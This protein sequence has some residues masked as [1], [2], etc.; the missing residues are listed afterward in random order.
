[1]AMI[2]IPPRGNVT[3]KFNPTPKGLIGANPCLQCLSEKELLA[4]LAG[5]MATGASVSMDSLIQSSKCFNCLSKKEM[6]QGIISI[7][8]QSVLV[9]HTVSEVIQD[10]HC[11]VCAP[12]KQLLAAIL[13]L[14]TN[15]NI[16]I[17]VPQN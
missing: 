3:L 10:M 12:E 1:M 4:A 6:L 13:F 15:G 16:T 11:L 5:V 8:G 17:S 2:I 14:L 9:G 7:V